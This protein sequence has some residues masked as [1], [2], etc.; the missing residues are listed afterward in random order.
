M[1][2]WNPV[3]SVTIDGDSYSEHTLNSITI[4][5]GRL[6]IDQQSTPAT[7]SLELI[8]FNNTAYNFDVNAPI[9]ITLQD[10]NGVAVP[11]FT[12][13][14]SDLAVAVK[15][16]GSTKT[17]TSATL[18]ALGAISILSRN[19]WAN[20]YSQD[21]EGN[22]IDLILDSAPQVS[23]GSIDTPGQYQ[24]EQRN[25]GL[26]PIYEILSLIANSAQ[27]YIWESGD[28]LINYWDADH[29]RN[30]LTTEGYQYFSAR[31]AIG[32]QVKTI[33]RLSD[34]VNVTYL[35]YGPNYGQQ[36]TAFN[37]SSQLLYGTYEETI[38]TV[39]HNA[40]EAQDAAVRRVTLRAFPRPFLDSLS[41][42]L[43]N[44]NLTNAERN[45]L[46]RIFVGM[47][48]CINDLPANISSGQFLGFVERFSFTGSQGNV[49]LTF[50]AS[51]SIFS[52]PPQDWNDVLT[53]ALEWAD[54]DPTL[55]WIGLAETDI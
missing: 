55:T 45:A 43:G 52:I 36:K 4:T 49:M 3:W 17:V 14:V 47:P 44:P 12:G 6:N 27:G 11:L 33:N 35:N 7:A 41:F 40:T 24:I 37:S 48:V 16:T 18:S 51:Q 30:Y 9:S 50:Q 42:P 10:S 46:I 28:G 2:N 20:N 25:A 13:V 53:P 22:I 54:V 29:R 31:D 39:L 8:N 23:K 26:V 32:R 34:I 19:F 5:N 15:S 1:T 38:N 21:T